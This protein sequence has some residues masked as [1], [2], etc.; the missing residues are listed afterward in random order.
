ML[1]IIREQIRSRFGS[2]EG[3]INSVRDQ[4]E[5]FIFFEDDF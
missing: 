4:V 5:S 1:V 3:L 2:L